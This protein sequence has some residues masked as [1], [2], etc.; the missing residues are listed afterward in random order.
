M[1]EDCERTCRVGFLFLDELKLIPLILGSDP[2]LSQ[3][4]GDKNHITVSG[5][6]S[7]AEKKKN[8]QLLEKQKCTRRVK[9]WH[10]KL[11]HECE[12]SLFWFRQLKRQFLKMKQTFTT[13][14]Y[15][16]NYHYYPSIN[17]F[18]LS[19]GLIDWC[20]LSYEIYLFII[21]LNN[22]RSR[23]STKGKKTKA[24]K[25]KSRPTPTCTRDPQL[26]FVLLFFFSIE[27]A[28][29][30]RNCRYDKKKIKRLWKNEVDRLICQD[31]HSLFDTHMKNCLCVEF[32]LSNIGT[33][34]R[35]NN[36]FICAEL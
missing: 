5:H 21:W 16:C 17:D 25:R 20:C 34:A 10:S 23:C 15:M 22:D 31:L 29:F 32:E 1:A 11:R 35:K 3:Q 36:Q 6:F 12:E 4:S 2:L 33:F 13:S 9:H 28:Q 26:Y 18:Y 24:L 7:R 8:N 14:K 30:Y 27:I 19:Y